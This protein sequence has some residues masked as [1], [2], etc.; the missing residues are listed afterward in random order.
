MNRKTWEN[1]AM[2]FGAGHFRGA[3]ERHRVLTE[4]VP[5]DARNGSVR[6]SNCVN[7]WRFDETGLLENGRRPPMQ[8][9]SNTAGN[10]DNTSVERIFGIEPL[11]NP[12]PV[13][14]KVENPVRVYVKYRRRGGI[15]PQFLSRVDLSSR[16]LLRVVFS[17]CA[18]ANNESRM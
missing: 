7:R 8:P 18:D 3:N 5:S 16:F 1:G 10:V 6:T 12:L 9:H 13:R 17:L 14:Q 15:Y 2:D 4:R 11:A